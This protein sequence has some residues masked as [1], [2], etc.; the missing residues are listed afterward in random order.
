M[1][2]N[3]AYSLAIITLVAIGAAIVVYMVNNI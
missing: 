1:K 3:T 2:R